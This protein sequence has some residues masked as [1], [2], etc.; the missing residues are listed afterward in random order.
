[1]TQKGLS[2]ALKAIAIAMALCGLLIYIY[3]V[4]VVLNS[5]IHEGQMLASSFLPLLIPIYITAIPVYIALVFGFK[6][7]CE[8]GADNSF[9]EKNATLLKNISYLAITDTAI[10]AV[11]SIT[12]FILKLCPGILILFFVLVVFAGIVIFIITAALSHLVY[13]AA[14]MKQ[15]QDL[16]I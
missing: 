10:V 2:N 15:E 5:Y 1:M 7:A 14:L 12:S 13:K 6:I 8:I 11:L 9:S 3:I 16:T 4:P